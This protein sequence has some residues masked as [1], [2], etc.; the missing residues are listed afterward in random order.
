MVGMIKRLSREVRPDLKTSW[1]L[2]KEK[3]EGN[4]FQIEIY[5]ETVRNNKVY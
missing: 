4:T 5:V 1:D 3:N 2:D